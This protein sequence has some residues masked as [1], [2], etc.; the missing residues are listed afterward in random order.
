MPQ[1]RGVGQAKPM[2]VRQYVPRNYPF[3][4]TNGVQASYPEV[5]PDTGMIR[6]L[7]H[8]VVED[9]GTILNPQLVDEQVGGGVVQRLGAALFEQCRYD[10]RGQ[11][12]NGSMADY[13]VPMAVETPDAAVGHVVSP[14]ADGELGA[15][16]A[17]EAGTAAAVAH[18]VTDALAPFQAAITEIPLTP[19]VILRALGR[20]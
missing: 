4:F 11:M 7:G 3:S 2:A 18:A 8:C 10:E 17:G 19:E 20:I 12:L 16:G 9:Y 15:K 1:Y 14:T 5:E 13:L 6:L